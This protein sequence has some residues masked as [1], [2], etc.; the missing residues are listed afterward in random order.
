MDDTSIHTRPAR[1]GSGESDG[2]LADTTACRSRWT[3]NCAFLSCLAAAAFIPDTSVRLSVVALATGSLAWWWLAKERRRQPKPDPHGGI[4]HYLL[5]ILLLGGLALFMSA[6][7]QANA[8]L[9]FL[10]NST[11]IRLVH[12]VSGGSLLLLWLS[13]PRGFVRAATAISAAVAVVVSHELYIRGEN[14]EGTYALL[15]AVAILLAGLRRD[16]P[17]AIGWARTVLAA[18]AKENPKVRGGASVVPAMELPDGPAPLAARHSRDL[19]GRGAAELHAYPVQFTG[20]AR[21]YFRIWVTNMSLSIVTLGVYSAWAKV[22]NR[23]YLMGNTIVNGHGFDYHA[24]PH[25]ILAARIAFLAVL[26]FHQVFVEVFV[27]AFFVLLAVVPWLFTRKFAFESRNSS[28]RTVRF[29]FDGRVRDI[30]LFFIPAF[31]LTAALALATDTFD[32][33]SAPTAG[34]FPPGLYLFLLALPVLAFLTRSLHRYSVSHRLFGSE[35][36]SHNAGWWP[37]VHAF[38]VVPF[39]GTCAV[40]LA[41]ALI[42]LLPYGRGTIYMTGAA[43]LLVTYPTF[44]IARAV[45]KK[46]LI[47]SIRFEGGHVSCNLG[48]WRYGCLVAGTGLLSLCTLGLLLPWAVTVRAKA[49]AKATTVHCTPRFMESVVDLSEREGSA[50]GQE[51]FD[52]LG[53]DIGSI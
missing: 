2:P 7:D 42:S 45:L 48:A 29:G 27:P 38:L 33:G 9:M 32:P 31:L 20:D 26:V 49:L 34:E 44:T 19:E 8:Q 36:L 40:S 50:I 30:Y 47:G 22:R 15:A 53:I 23:R 11:A 18:R 12:T 3:A 51:G 52:I 46:A 39:A 28:Y 41:F 43:T 1:S 14:K 5:A 4:P 24:N 25:S 37:Y 10:T 13:Y 6:G 35:R 17:V 21:E 16:I